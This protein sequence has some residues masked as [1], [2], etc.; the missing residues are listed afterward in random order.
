MMEEFIKKINEQYESGDYSGILTTVTEINEY[1]GS[2]NNIISEMTEKTDELSCSVEKVTAENQKLKS[3]NAELFLKVNGAV[4][5]STKQQPETA[6]F[7][8]WINPDD[9]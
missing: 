3:A 1:V 5:L 2:L 7:K 8:A 6:D 9:F 4:D